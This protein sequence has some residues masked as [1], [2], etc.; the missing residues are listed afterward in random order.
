[1]FSIYS[2]IYSFIDD[3]YFSTTKDRYL[4][5]VSYITVNEMNSQRWKENEKLVNTILQRTYVDSAVFQ[6]ASAEVELILT[7]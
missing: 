1:M 7:D 5:M 2:S 4:L 3:S 6:V